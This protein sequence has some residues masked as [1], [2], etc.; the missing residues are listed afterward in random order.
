MADIAAR[1]AE[2]PYDFIDINMGCPV[3]K[4][5]NNG[6]GSALMKNPKLV[7]QIVSAMTKKVNKPVTVKIRKGFYKNEAN[8][9]EVAKAAEAGGCSLIAVHGRTREDYYYGTADWD[10]IREVKNAVKVP[11]IGNGDIKSGPDAKRMLEETGCDGIMIGRAARGNPW[12]FREVRHFL[13]TG[14]ELERPCLDDIKQMI[15]KHSRDIIA[16]KGEFTGI[17]EMRKHVAWYIGGIKNAAAIRN[18]VNY[19]ETFEE[20]SNLINTELQ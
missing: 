1:V 19:V 8:A 18:K 5:V 2:G 10:I 3:P 4:I 11:V 14:E 7:E 6:E 16:Y 17:R 20:L 9:A 15:L 12:I 13:E